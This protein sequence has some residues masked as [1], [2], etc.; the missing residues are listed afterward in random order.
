MIKSITKIMIVV[1]SLLPMTT[2]AQN[3]DKLAQFNDYVYVSG[4]LG[5]GF[6]AGD[7]TGLKVLSA[8]RA[9]GRTART[10]TLPVGAS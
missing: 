10:P 2:F 4:D 3:N 7:N 8:A 1:L 6:L 9:A 5:L